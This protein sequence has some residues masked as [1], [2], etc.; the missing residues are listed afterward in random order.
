MGFVEQGT[1][2]I[3]IDI[4]FFFLG[5]GGGGRGGACGGIG[6]PTFSC[7]FVAV[8]CNITTKYSG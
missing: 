1:G 3:D 7:P 2:C 4:I 6:S 5:G 8:I